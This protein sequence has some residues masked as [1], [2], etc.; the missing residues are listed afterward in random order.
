MFVNFN[1]QIVSTKPNAKKED[2]LRA[3]MEV[4]PGAKKEAKLGT[5]KEAK[6]N[7]K[8]EVKIGTKK[9]AKV[10]AKKEAK[11]KAILKCRLTLNLASRNYSKLKKNNI[12]IHH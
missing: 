1:L 11:P 8:K 2:K 4:K 12:K 6:P 3:K 5:K 7:N 9:E 10:G